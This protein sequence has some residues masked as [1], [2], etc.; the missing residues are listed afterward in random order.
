VIPGLEFTSLRAHMNLIGVKTPMKRPNLLWPSKQAIKE[1]I[2]HA[3]GEGGVVQLN[4]PAWYPYK[5]LKS[6][7]RNWWLAQGL[8]GW[9]VYNGFGFADEGALDF[10][11]QNEGK[12]VMFASAGTDVHDPAKHHRVY[13]DVLTTDRTLN[14]V[15]EALKSGKTR[16]Y[17]VMNTN[18]DADRP[19]RGKLV[20]DPARQAYI[21]K[22]AWLDWIGIGLLQGKNTRSIELFVVLVLALGVVL[23]MVL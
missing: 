17:Q 7:P 1:A 10:I 23:S 19:E 5:I 18:Q 11:K 13:T 3:H 8:D 15:M 16:V 6:L 4:H 2:N 9:E 14:G 12:R 21:K 20:L 22:W